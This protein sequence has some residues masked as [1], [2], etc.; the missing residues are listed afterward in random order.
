MIYHSTR[1]PGQSDYNLPLEIHLCCH[2]TGALFLNIT[3][4]QFLKTVTPTVSWVTCYFSKVVAK[5]I[6]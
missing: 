3:K 1:D 4:H 5:Y 2:I 6:A